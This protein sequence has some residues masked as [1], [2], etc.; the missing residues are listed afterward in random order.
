MLKELD[1]DGDMFHVMLDEGKQTRK[2]VLGA[3]LTVVTN[4][5]FVLCT[6]LKYDTMVGYKNTT[7][8]MVSHD[9]EIGDS[10]VFSDQ[11]M[12]NVAVGI[13]DFDNQPTFIEDPDY[14]TLQARIYMWGEQDDN[15]IDG[16]EHLTMHR[17]TYDEVN[18]SEEEN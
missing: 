2:T 3:L 4:V 15:S 17:C 14:G 16:Y 9:Y 11:M 13:T 7:H 1:L 10:Y 8:N 18:I 5:I 12:F 6:L